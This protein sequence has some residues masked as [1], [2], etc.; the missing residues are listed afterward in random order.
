MKK[1]RLGKTNLKVSEVGFGG[2]PII[3]LPFDEAVSVV[4]QCFELGFNFFDTAN[5][6]KDSEEKLGA[7][8]EP[9]RENVVIASKTD[10]RKAAAAAHHIDLSLQRLQTDRID[11]YQLHDVS[12]EDALQQVLGPGGAYEALDKARDRGKIRFI[13]I[14]S[15][16]IPVAIKALDTDLFET[17]QFPFNFIENDPVDELFPLARRM[18]VGLIGMKPLGGGALERADL[19]FGF[20]QQ[21]PYVVPIPGIQSIAEAREILDLYQTPVVLEK[22]DLAAMDKIKNTVGDKFCHRCEYCLPCEQGVKIPSVL[23]FEGFAKR[24]SSE[25]AAEI[26]EEAMAG[27]E[28]CIECGHCEEKCPYNLP[29]PGLLKENLALFKKCNNLQAHPET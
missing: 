28:N 24:F 20:L 5:A 26:M 8:L 10:E 21:H 12:N 6:Y 25:V 4:R 19:C 3:P 27:V 13:G 23:I 7:A 16:N 15:H 14:S 1:I 18:D 22:S 9:F 29:I 11:I 17:L 2:I